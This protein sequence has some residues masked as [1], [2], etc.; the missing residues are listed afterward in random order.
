MRSRKTTASRS[1]P[2]SSV[3]SSVILLFVHHLGRHGAQ[4]RRVADTAVDA[5]E[6]LSGD[7]AHGD[8][9]D[10]ELEVGTGGA[11]ITGAEGGD[12]CAERGGVA[13]VS[14]NAE[15][16]APEDGGCQCEGGAEV[17]LMT[18][19]R[20]GALAACRHAHESARQFEVLAPGFWR[21]GK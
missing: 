7:V 17:R 2:Y 6:A 14:E 19:R 15:F 21:A 1:A 3:I 10:G 20:R 8:L 5:H 18:E 13:D 12:W 11:R 4:Q 9:A 16:L